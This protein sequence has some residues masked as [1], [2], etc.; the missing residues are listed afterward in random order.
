MR[1]NRSF[2]ARNE[3]KLITFLIQRVPSKVAPVHLTFVGLSGSV[4]SMGALIGMNWS[5]GLLCFA[6]VGIVF[7][8][9]GDSLDGSLA[10]YRKVER[11]RFGFLVDH[12]SDLFSQVMIISGFGFSPLFTPFSAM[13]VLVCYL[14]FSAYTYIRV[15]AQHV[16]QMS[17]IG[18][19][20]TEFRL[21]LIGWC[22]IGS[23][24]EP[25]LHQKVIGDMPR[26]DLVLLILSAFALVGL[27]FKAVSDAREISVQEGAKASADDAL[28]PGTREAAS[29]RS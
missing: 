5:P 17:Y 9:F 11:P 10:R 27:V 16:H 25:G 7:N 8:W 21:L 3:R 18:V 4:I 22:W 2:L 13:L 1:D 24:L 26:L 15:C 14:F 23:L 20:A 6:P 12:T 28:R 19:G 29:P